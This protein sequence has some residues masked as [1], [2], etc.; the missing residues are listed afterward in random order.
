MSKITFTENVVEKA[1]LA[2][3]ETLGYDIVHGS[4]IS[5]GE[6]SE[7]R[8]SY[9]EVILKDK[10]Y[11]AMA[12]VNSD[13]PADVLDEA[14]RKIV[15]VEF[16][17]LVE[18]NRAFHNM[19]VNGIDVDIAQPDGSLRGKKIW[20]IDFAYPSNNDFCA[21][22]QLT[23]REGTN[24][25]RLDVV[26][27]LNGLALVV[28]ELKN[29]VNHVATIRQAY[30]QL[31]TY[32][33]EIP[34]LFR[35]NA[36][37]V[38]SDG[39]EARM[40]SLTAG[41]ER[42]M[43]WRT[44]DGVSIEP[45]GKAEL[46]VLIKGL[47]EKN[48]LVDFI[49]NF[50]VFE[51]QGKSVAK[52]VAAYHQYHG[53][54]TAVECTISASSESGDKRIGVVWH[55]QGSGK[56]LSMAFYAGKIVQHKLMKNP[57]LV[58]VTD[59]NDLD[60][61]LYRT[62]CGCS[63]LVR[64][65]PV[66]ARNRRHLIDLLSVASGGVVFTTLQ[67]FM[68]DEDKA[69]PS[70]SNR[71][72]V[73]VIVD[74]AHRSQYEFVSG[75]ARHMRDGLPRASFIGF[76]ATPIEFTNKD[77]YAVFGDN[78][79]TYD[80]K[81]AVEDGATVKIYYESRHARIELN[82][83]IAPYLEE[84]FQE[85]TENEEVER[86]EQLKSKWI[87]FETLVGSKERISLIARD[88][89]VH[90]ESRLEAL[91]GKAMFVCMSRRICVELYSEIAKLRPSWSKSG[92][93]VGKM[94]VVMTGSASDPTSYQ[95]HIRNK[96]GQ[97]VIAHRAKDPSDPLQ[98]VIVRD[99]WLTGFDAPPMHT[100]YIDKRMEGHGLM[101]AIARVNRVFGGK[102]GGLIVD[103]IGI[104]KFLKK[105]LS[106]YSEGD[107]RATGILQEDAIATMQE[108]Y[109][110]VKQL[111]HRF[112][113]S[114]VFTG[115]PKEK[116]GVI[117]AA[118]EHILTQENGRDR[119]IK[120]SMKLANSFALCAASDEAKEIRDEVGFFQSVRFAF[121]KSTIGQRKNLNLDTIDIALQQLVS[122]AI[123]PIEVIDIFSAAGLSNPDISILSDEF[124]EEI[125]QLTHKN[126]ALEILRK[127][128][129]DEIGQR[130]KKNVVQA[131]SFTE[132]LES[133]IRQYHE[134]LVEVTQAIEQL[135]L[136]ATDL[137]DEKGRKIALKLGDDELAILDALSEK[138][139]EANDFEKDKL[140]KI[141]RDLT[142][143]IKQEVSIDWKIRESTRAGIRVTVKRTLRKYEFPKNLIDDVTHTVLEQA[144]HFD[145]E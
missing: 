132:M 4:D 110:L 55:T 66:Q 78:I 124:L 85:V 86:K 104:A 102:P 71:T 106:N 141:S 84:K 96:S 88:L 15:G 75:F 117:P 37:L 69:Y 143:L 53:V 30:H 129:R 70:L 116:L 6:G 121:S 46:E 99:M 123:A 48:V 133:T 68:S 5:P 23:V 20:L 103:Y 26:I 77:T 97:E 111:F 112:D 119:Y 63:E 22:S 29:A 42:Y 40:G 120:S 83:S 61:Q 145:E 81:Q 50:V 12:T 8:A 130:L 91:D 56:S 10:L 52:I 90:L 33:R 115:S 39:I 125:R 107:R 25:R 140:V 89:V 58:F 7:R 134:R 21:V 49:R 31:Q 144:E 74:E 9:S 131:R 14:Y 101:Q 18:S 87:R 59:R 73:V 51:S 92:D 93:K 127:S 62:L 1:A 126:L 137:R 35:T 67:K 32:I 82:K 3:Y 135:I 27:Y 16:H 94:K 11:S 118:M 142:K 28:V 17:D 65:I 128:L 109:E 100:M 41:I 139:G 80:M 54:N 122:K 43:P 114:S 105:A 79:H 113:Y 34:S 57:T 2:W 98:L 72:N 60:N 138:V 44:V 36:F 64:Q 38:I 108:M 24:N 95:S 47:F 76:T 136:I 13:I 45:R 19:I